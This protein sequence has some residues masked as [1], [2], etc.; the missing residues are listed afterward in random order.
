MSQFTFYITENT[1]SGAP[2]MTSYTSE[3]GVYGSKASITVDYDDSYG[4]AKLN[5]TDPFTSNNPL[6]LVQP[7]SPNSQTATIKFNGDPADNSGSLV[8]ALVNV[9]D[10]YNNTFPLQITASVI[11]SP[12]PIAKINGANSFNLHITENTSSGAPLMD[13]YSPAEGVHGNEAILEIFYRG[14]HGSQHVD[15]FEVMG[16]SNISVTKINNFSA[17]LHYTSDPKAQGGISTFPQIKI[18]DNHGNEKLQTITVSAQSS[19]SPTIIGNGSVD[20]NGDG[21]INNNVFYFSENTSADNPLKN[22][23]SSAEGV[24]GTNGILTLTYDPDNI[25]GH[26]NQSLASYTNTNDSKISASLSGNTVNLFY[27]GNPKNDIG[28]EIYSLFTFTDNFDNTDLKQVTASIVSSPNPTITDNGN[29][30]FHY[31]ITENTSSNAPLHVSN[32]ESNGVYGNEAIITLAYFQGHSNQSLTTVVSSNSNISPTVSGNTI[33]LKYGGTP[34]SDASTQDTTLTITDNHNNIFTHDIDVDIISSPA[35]TLLP[36]VG[37]TDLDFNISQNSPLNT[38]V[39][40]DGDLQGAETIIELKY[41][42]N[43]TGGHG[44]QTVASFTDNLDSVEL[45]DQGYNRYKIKYTDNPGDVTTGQGS[46]DTTVRYYDVDF[47]FTDNFDNIDTFSSRIYIKKSP[48]A[49]IT[50]NHNN[51]F[52]YYITENT[53]SGAP[54]K[55]Q[56]NSST[57]NIYSTGTQNL[58]IRG[59]EADLNVSYN[60]QGHPSMQLHETTPFVSNNNK[61]TVNNDGNL[62]YGGTTN[63]L[64]SLAG[65]E[66]HAHITVKDNFN[67]TSLQEV[68]ASII[69]TPNA[70]FRSNQSPTTDFDFYIIQSTSSGAPLM[71]DYTYTSGVNNGDEVEINHLFPY[72][73]GNL[74]VDHNV[75]TASSLVSSNNKITSTLVSD[76]TFKLNFNGNPG[77]SMGTPNS[78][79]LLSDTNIDSTL[80]MTDTFG[81]TYSQAIIVTVFDKS[82]PTWTHG[83]QE[84]ID[85]NDSG[86]IPDNSTIYTGTISIKE[87]DTDFTAVITGTDSSDYSSTITGTTTR[88]LKIKTNKNITDT[89]N[90]AGINHSISVRVSTSGHPTKF[91]DYSLSISYDSVAPKV[92]A[93][94]WSYSSQNANVYGNLP[95]FGFNFNNDLT[96]HDVDEY[97]ANSHQTNPILVQSSLIANGSILDLLVSHSAIGNT[98][99]TGTH[100]GGTGTSGTNTARSTSYNLTKLAEINTLTNLQDTSFENTTTDTKGLSELGNLKL[101]DSSN[102]NGKLCIIFPRSSQF[103]FIPTGMA[104]YIGTSPDNTNKLKL[105]YRN[106]NTGN[107]SVEASRIMYFTTKDY[108]YGYNQWAAIL[109]LKSNSMTDSKFFL[110]NDG[111]DPTV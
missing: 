26:G 60:V 3:L 21:N 70:L 59:N 102:N 54:L 48:T 108:I 61:I 20:F 51:S 67:R 9:R 38:F 96:S 111:E 100:I 4:E 72:G 55:T 103:S 10:N 64:Q 47:S 30:S 27:V 74:F 19:P 57:T 106:T 68:T 93:Y 5:V 77:S 80:T 99:I 29:N 32:N 76:N 53:E 66:L 89:S 28:N 39:N 8:K 18:T 85:F 33:I 69:Q 109:S 46:S 2:L 56:Y 78:T 75:V 6:I 36:I 52:Q 14:G 50:D 1:E 82:A 49:T 65:T 44:S 45:I 41:D 40:N 37:T 31:Y 15:T 71:T 62:F 24:H 63:E 101:T 84:D 23:S 12:V 81:N 43:D 98:T 7:I 92:M 25:G 107:P 34:K 90:G 91:R 16:A 88:T 94:R 58:G 104:E 17:S 110:I 35:P 97:T 79:T 83:T 95:N 73:H 105:T 86:I 42:P 22:D 11:N 13:D 87:G